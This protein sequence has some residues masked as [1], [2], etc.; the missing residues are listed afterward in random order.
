MKGIIDEI[1]DDYVVLILEGGM[2]EIKVVRALTHLPDDAEVGEWV[3]ITI[4]ID[5][6]MELT[7]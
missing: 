2:G 7:F 5:R 1:E 3:E 4:K 6:D